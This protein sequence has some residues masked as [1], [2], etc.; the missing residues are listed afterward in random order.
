MPTSRQ[1][2][3]KSEIATHLTRAER[4]LAAGVDI[5]IREEWREHA[6]ARDHT[7]DIAVAGGCATFV[8]DLLAD[9]AG[10]AIWVRLVGQ[11]L[12]TVLDCRLTTSWDAHIVPASFA[13]QGDSMCRL[14]LLQYPRN[15]V[16]NMRIQN[17]L[18]F[19]RGQTI[20]GVILAT[21]V[22][23]IPEAYRHGLIVPIQ[24]AFLDQNEN[25][26][27]GNGELFVDRLSK[28]RRKFVPRKSGL[29]DRGG[30]SPTRE[31]VTRQ[32]SS[33]PQAPGLDGQPRNRGAN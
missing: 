16:L 18:R 24:V 3:T 6:R 7:L 2:L 25:E 27:R 28:S 11:A 31:P 8:F 1:R 9:R 30:I 23:P 5:Q 32:D 20:E 12:G 17:S 21:G 33:V 15:Q 10:Y 29:Y 4:M 14:G 19:Q 13:D 22:N 26:I